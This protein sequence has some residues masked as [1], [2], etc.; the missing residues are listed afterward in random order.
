VETQVNNET[1]E[2]LKAKLAAAEA[3][4]QTLRDNAGSLMGN[5][6]RSMATTRTKPQYDFI[7]RVKGDDGFPAMQ[8]TAVDESEAI[9]LYVLKN[10]K[11]GKPLDTVKLQWDVKMAPGEADRRT[12]ANA[13]AHRLRLNEAGYSESGGL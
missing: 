5:F 4:N 7:V 11:D 13:E 6:P 1:V 12:K 3:E 8:V 10:G 9:R 2:S